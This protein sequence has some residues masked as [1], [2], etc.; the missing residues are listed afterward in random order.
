MQT[1]TYN[2]RDGCSRRRAAGISLPRM[3]AQK[4][5]GLLSRA[6]RLRLCVLFFSV[7]RPFLPLSPTRQD[8]FSFLCLALLCLAYVALFRL[9]S[10]P[11]QLFLSFYWTYAFGTRFSCCVRL[12]EQKNARLRRSKQRGKE[13][14]RIKRKEPELVLRAVDGELLEQKNDTLP[15]FEQSANPFSIGKGVWGCFSTP[16]FSFLLLYLYAFTL[17]F[18]C[19]AFSFS[20]LC[21]P[22]L[23]SV[24]YFAARG[25]VS[26][27]TA[28]DEPRLR[29]HTQSLLNCVSVFYK[30]T[31]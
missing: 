31:L 17:F 13:M 4:T 10:P 9:T 12:K 24:P 20:F 2:L 23:L 6:V 28:H 19:F 3:P 26:A 1:F 7:R 25:Y 27:H 29:K 16:H 8:S 30:E 5:A 18:F 21:H 14:E 15:G 11:S 22:L